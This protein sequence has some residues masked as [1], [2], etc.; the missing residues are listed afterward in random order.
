M[1]RN[2]TLLGDARDAVGAQTEDH[3]CFV[4]DFVEGGN[5]YSDLM[6]GPYTHER[7][8]FYAAQATPPHNTLS[9]HPAPAAPSPTPTSPVPHHSVEAIRTLSRR[10]TPLHVLPVQIVLA[11]QHLHELDV[12]YRD[13]KPDNVLLTIDGFVKLADMGAARGIS[14]DG[15]ISGGD[16][17]TTSSDKTAKAGDPSKQRRMTITGTH[18]Y[19]APEVYERDYGKEAD[20]WNVGILIIEMLSAEN[21]LR[22]ENRRES[23]YLTK[24]KDLTLPAYFKDEAKKISLDFL[25]RDPKKRLGCR[26]LGVQE[27]KDH[28]FFQTIKLDWEKLMGCTHPHAAHYPPAR[29]H[30]ADCPHTAPAHSARTQRTARTAARLCEAL[31]WP[32]TVALRASRWRGVRISWRIPWRQAGDGASFRV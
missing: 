8:V 25:N 31:I 16:Q 11:T 32:S 14:E 22:G 4:L 18:G 20:W 15:T 13:L 6:R 24:H 23:E 10:I 21:P 29:P 1:L 28:P 27:V 26:E 12:L 30:A 9:P 17:A 3:L 19:R 7:A 2:R 5:M